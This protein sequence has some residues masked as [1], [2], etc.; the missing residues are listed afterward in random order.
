LV[1]EPFSQECWDKEYDAILK[2]DKDVLS[3]D[4]LN[5]LVKESDLCL[6]R[7]D[8]QQILPI[9]LKSLVDPVTNTIKRES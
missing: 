7:D 4:I 5:K 1:Y 3:S 6:V 2:F 8:K 9:S